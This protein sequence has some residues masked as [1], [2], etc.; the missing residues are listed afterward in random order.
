MDRNSIAID[1]IKRLRK[2]KNFSLQELATSLHKSKSAWARKESGEVELTLNEIDEVAKAM[3]SDFSE[4]T[5]AGVVIHNTNSGNFV[6]NGTNPILIIH[7]SEE[8]FEEISNLLK[9]RKK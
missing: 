6:S 3:D 2:E 1:A 9:N 8:Q 5:N 4:I 7:P